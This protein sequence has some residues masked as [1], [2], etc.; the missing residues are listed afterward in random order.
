MS[1]GRTVLADYARFG[2]ALVPIPLGSKGPVTA[3]WNTREMCVTEPDVAEYLD[4]NVGLAHAYSG[5]CALDVDDIEKTR[6]WLSARGIDLDKYLDAPDAVRIESRPG[7]AKLIYKLAKP[8]PSFKVA[9]GGLELRCASSTGTTV[10]DVLPPSIHPDT[11]K[12][13]TWRYGAGVTSWS[14]LGFLPEPIQALWQSLV[15]VASKPARKSPASTRK[16]IENAPGLAALLNNLDPDAG[17]HDWL[18]VGMALHHE[19]GGRPEGLAL[20]NE[21]SAA[22]SKYKG[23]AD[24]ESHYRSFRLNHDNP[25]TL[26]SLRTETPADPSEF[27]DLSAAPAPGGVRPPLPPT[28]PPAPGRSLSRESLRALKYTKAGT[29]EARLSNVVNMLDVPQIV[30]VEFAYDSFLDAIM[31]SEDGGASW[32][33]LTD[34]D[35]TSL[36]VTLETI[37]NCEPIPHEMIRHA[38]ALVAEQN[39]LDSAQTWLT[40]LQWDGI[41]RIET[42]CPDYF[43]TQ[44][45]PY[46]RAVGLYMWT[47]L[48]GRIMD[49]GCQADMVPTLISDEG[50]GK[51]RGI[52]AMVPAPEH[53]VVL[54]LDEPDDTIARKSRGVLAAEF[55]EMRGLRAAD[56]D[57]VKEFVT[58]SSE[59][60][61]P[62]FRE[63]STTYPRRFLIIGSTNDEEFLP[64]ETGRRRWLPLHTEGVKVDAIAADRDQLWAEALIRW[65]LD[66]VC[67]QGLDQLATHARD[68]AQGEDAW[69]EDI[70]AWIDQ[71]V[72]DG[73]QAALYV[74]M[75]D[76][77]TQAVGLDARQY[78]RVHELRAARILR[79]MGYTRRTIRLGGRVVKIWASAA[80]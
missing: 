29:I 75:R 7:R 57:R 6:T 19:T 52:Q 16:I 66:G 60:W 15:P 39:K 38:V 36:R 10:Q 40:R 2:W 46:E 35:Y 14:Q 1:D 34:T 73:G 30:G 58:R 28:A 61:V 21:W 20:W 51:S 32:R 80:Y 70:A 3:R 23:L 43:G 76:V 79:D 72:K 74:K 8:L 77:L 41:E 47:A 22:G 49:P 18:A 68:A 56:A 33:D 65:Q 5:T 37:G 63:F 31:L 59:K 13:Y 55:A 9:D 48:A 27:P 24:L 64:R 71:N 53:F 26:A 45:A 78:T 25:I 44:D 67:W 69:L 17:Y 62:K 12:P 11:G 42:F 54:K 4:G 50:L